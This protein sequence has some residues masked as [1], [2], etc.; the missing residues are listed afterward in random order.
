MTERRLDHLDPAT[1]A[2][3][4]DRT[5]DPAARAEAEAHL[6]DCAD[7]REVWVETSEIAGEMSEATAVPPPV[8]TNVVPLRRRSR[9]LIYA[10]AGLAAAAAIGLAVFSPRLFDRGSRPELRDLVAAVGENRRTEGR[11]TGGFKWGPVPSVRRGS[12]KSADIDVDIAATTLQQSAAGA[13]EPLAVAAAGSA[14]L[15]RGDIESAIA[16]LTQ[17]TR[18]GSANAMVWSDLSAAYLERAR[19]S[20]DTAAPAAALEAADRALSLSADLAEARFNRALALTATGRVTEARAGWEHYLALDA[21]SPW[22]D[23]ARKRLAA[24]PANRHP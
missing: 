14:A 11:L 17:A 21:S 12:D 7:C 18:A 8:A 23:E 4:V 24:L 19:L 20:G 6:A 3:L 9:G 5:L 16:S 2:A 15:I 22:A 1:I 13:T 10:G